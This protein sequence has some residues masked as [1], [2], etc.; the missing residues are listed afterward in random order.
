[1]SQELT[2]YEN[3]QVQPHFSFVGGICSKG[4]FQKLQSG[5]HHNLHNY[6]CDGDDFLCVLG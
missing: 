3:A 5:A 2:T 6:D 4:L 1:M